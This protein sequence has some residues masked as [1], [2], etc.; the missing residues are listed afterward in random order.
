MIV[1]RE[2]CRLSTEV[3]SVVLPV[4]LNAEVINLCRPLVVDF[5]ESNDLF[6]RVAKFALLLGS[7]TQPRVTAPRARALDG[8]GDGVD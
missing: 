6:D 1:E 8:S 5:E 2:R 4:R 7:G 3:I